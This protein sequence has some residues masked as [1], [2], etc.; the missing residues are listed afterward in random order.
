MINWR[1]PYVEENREIL[2]WGGK[3]TKEKI[4]RIVSIG[5]MWFLANLF[6]ATILCT[7]IVSGET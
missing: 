5:A 4:T 6:G 1:I 7:M 2:K 3:F